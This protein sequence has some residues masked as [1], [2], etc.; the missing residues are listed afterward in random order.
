MLIDE[1]ETIPIQHKLDSLYL[2]GDYSSAIEQTL[3][4]LNYYKNKKDLKGQ[5]VCFNH[6]GDYLRASGNR[7]ESLESLY[8]ALALNAQLHDSL[9]L[10]QTYNYLGAIFFEQDYPRY[11]DS[12]THYAGL[13]MDIAVRHKDEK[14][15]YSDL[16]LLGMAEMGK[17]K[18]D[19]AL[20]YLDQALEMVKRI[21]PIDEP[22]VLCNMAGIYYR[23]NDLTIAKKLALRAFQKAKHDNVNTYIRMASTLL[24][25]FNLLEGN[26]R[27]AYYYLSELSLYT[28]N[29]MDEK[30]EGRMASMKEQF[31][32]AEE[33]ANVQKELNQRRLLTTFLFILFGLALV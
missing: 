23:K 32:Q 5:I 10:A 25:K 30:I 16:N 3:I 1:P 22:L 28:R 6:L 21:S 20:V 14:L 33:N 8:S 29:F 4:L 11:M 19:S 27:E 15:I 13:S 24:E 2:V 7:T 26:Y 12:T 18:L 9:L 31:R 17:D